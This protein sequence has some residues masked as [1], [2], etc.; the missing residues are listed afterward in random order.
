MEKGLAIEQ[1]GVFSV[2]HLL[3]Q[4][5][6]VYNGH[7]RGHVALTPAAERLAMELSL[8]VFFTT[9]VAAEYSNT[10]PSMELPDCLLFAFASLASYSLLWRRYQCIRIGF[11]ARLSEPFLCRHNTICQRLIIDAPSGSV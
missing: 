1:R 5:S 11:S 2:P 9:Y 7:L 8:P 10:Q 3:W 6:S 4:G